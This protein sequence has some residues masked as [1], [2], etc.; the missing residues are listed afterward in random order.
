VTF[1]PTEISE[2]IDEDKEGVGQTA[3]CA[4]CGVDSVI[5]SGS[6][7]PITAEF[8]TEMKKHWF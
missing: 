3:L 1:E 6:G 8:L 4:R 7:F 2:W 5:G